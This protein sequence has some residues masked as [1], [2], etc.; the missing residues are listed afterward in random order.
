MLR[1]NNL[2]GARIL[3]PTPP[4]SQNTVDYKSTVVN[5]KIAR[6]D[7]QTTLRLTKLVEPTQCTVASGFG[8]V[9]SLNPGNPVVPALDFANT[10]LGSTLPVYKR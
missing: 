9:L 10:R 1:L 6:T 2:L 5:E 8:Q 4:N 7:D 3:G